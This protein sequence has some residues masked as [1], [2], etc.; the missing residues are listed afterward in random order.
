M[1]FT[2]SEQLGNHI[3]LFAQDIDA[4]NN[5]TVYSVGARFIATRKYICTRCGYVAQGPEAP[6]SCPVCKGTDF[7]RT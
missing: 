4:L 6:A 1:I 7:V 2:E 5:T 3:K